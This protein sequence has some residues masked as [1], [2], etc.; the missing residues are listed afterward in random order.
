MKTHLKRWLPAPVIHRLKQSKTANRALDILGPVANRW[1]LRNVPFDQVYDDSYFEL[2]DRTSKES[3][4]IMAN[5]LV[6]LFHPSSAIDVG[7][8]TGSLLAALETAGIDARGIEKA[9]SALAYCRQ[10]NLHVIEADL[11]PPDVKDLSGERFDLATC[12]EVGHQVAREHAAP[13]VA[14]LCRL[15][16]RVV[17]SADP[18]GDDRLPL[19]PKPPRYWIDLFAEE[20]FGFDEKA[21]ATLKE[22]WE[23]RSVAH[24]F[25]R[26]PMVFRKVS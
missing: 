18:G 21:S 8:G 25:S 17:F 14:F 20:G 24:W 7:C 1:R 16:D 12:F 22:D 15:A 23:R 9:Q 13:L 10:R 2:I 11:S 19:N 4:S 26:Y 6:S 3:S 5:S